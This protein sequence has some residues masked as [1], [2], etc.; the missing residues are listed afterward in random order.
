MLDPTGE[1]AT[2]AH[3]YVIPQAH[4]WLVVSHC[5]TVTEFLVEY[6]FLPKCNLRFTDL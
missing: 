6:E 3:T 2:P 1:L 4:G 5:Q